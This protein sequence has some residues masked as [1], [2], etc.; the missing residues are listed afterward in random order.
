MSVE[1]KR[2]LGGRRILVAGTSGP[3]SGI[4]APLVADGA[5]LVV[6]SPV[7]DAGDDEVAALGGV[8]R[9]EC[10]FGSLATVRDGVKAALELLGGVDQF[11]FAWYP[12]ALTNAAN[13]IDVN[14]DE[15]VRA[16]E[17]T[18]DAAWWSVRDLVDPLR[19]SKNGSIVFVVPTVGM[20]GASGFVMLSIVAEGL[21]MLA[22]SCG[23]CWGEYGINVNTLAVSPSL[24][25]SPDD[26]KRLLGQI[27]I[28]VPAMG[29]AGDPEADLSPLVA[30]LGSDEA[31]FVTAGTLVAD[32]GLWMGL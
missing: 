13:L 19:A 3:V 7:S 22:K 20:S 4:I 25:L 31:H 30:L 10:D 26:G 1:D 28:S 17:G 24:W 8:D 15:W 6:M 29:R 9:V 32:G 21:R 16:C 11:V 27:A 12:A 18:L 23:R 2:N 5:H 14:E